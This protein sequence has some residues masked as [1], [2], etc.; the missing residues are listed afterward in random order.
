MTN[1]AAAK[2]ASEPSM[3]NKIFL[4]MVTTPFGESK[5]PSYGLAATSVLTQVIQIVS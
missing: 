2:A 1:R 3:G 4:N 5:N